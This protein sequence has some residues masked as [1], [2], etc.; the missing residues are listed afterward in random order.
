MIC[1][2]CFIKWAGFLLSTLFLTTANANEVSVLD[3]KARQLND[4][5]WTFA[6]TLKHNDAGWD[7]YANKWQIIDA[8]NKI[9]GTRTLYHPHVHEQPFTRNLSGVKI[10][11]GTKSVRVIAKDTVH[12]LSH[13]AAEINLDNK[14]VKQITLDLKKATQE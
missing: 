8:K 11:E 10:P 6:V 7:H 14:Q 2:R 12:G 4:K 1:N 5:T 13:N 9:L 3:I